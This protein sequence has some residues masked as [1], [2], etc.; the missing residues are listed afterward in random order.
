MKRALWLVCALLTGALAACQ[1][2]WVLDDLPPDA[3]RSGSG[4]TNGDGGGKGGF[5]PSDASMD[6]RCFGGQMQPIGATADKPLV[7]VALD[8]SSEMTGT[9]L[10]GSNSSEFN[11]A[12]NDLIGQVESYAPSGQHM[13]RR[14]IDFAYLGFP[15]GT[16]CMTPGCCASTGD[17]ADSYSAFSAATMTCDSPANGCGPSTDHPLAAALASASYFFEFGS[18][19]SPAQ[20]R[21][22]LVVT[23]DAP[24]GN[25]SVNMEDDC[26]AAQDQVV[27][28]YGSL[29]VTTVVVFVGTSPNTSC[30]PNFVDDQGGGPPPYYG[31]SNLYYNAQT[32]QDLQEKISTAIQAMAQGA[33]HF[34][35]SSAPSSPNDLNVSQ[36][37]T[38]IQPDSKNG[39]TYDNE[40]SGPRLILHGS[41]CTTYLGSN[42]QF[43]LQVSDGCSPN[44]S[45]PP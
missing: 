15:Q 41:A 34:S 42:S 37:N 20:E 35:L 6:G 36:G 13:N 4:G 38:P 31:D 3:G 32:A 21:Y 17:L 27:A 45:P 2:T 43:G 25:C 33:C 18:G 22:V 12:V 14:A 39:W 1:Q 29:N 16:T 23:D 19:G 26:H 40:S 11:E 8:R 7:L 28:L 44:H 10:D 30:F 24:D 9:E 5:S